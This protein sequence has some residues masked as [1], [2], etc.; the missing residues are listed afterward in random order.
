MNCNNCKLALESDANYCGNCGKPV[1]S[2]TSL[3]SVVNSPITIETIL[4]LYALPKHINNN[5]LRYTLAICAGIM[6]II[7][8]LFIPIVGLAFSVTGFIVIS[9]TPHGVHRKLKWSAFIL[10]IIGLL[11]SLGSIAYLA[12]HATS[13]ISNGKQSSQSAISNL[14]TPCYSA[15]FSPPVNLTKDLSSCSF[16]ARTVNSGLSATNYFKVISASQPKLTSINLLT[17]V[18]P[19]LEADARINLPGFEIINE[20]S[21]LF[22]GSPAYDIEL[23]NQNQKVSAIELAVLHPT[24]KGDN[25]FVLVNINSKTTA[26]LNELKSSW[27]WH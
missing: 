16:I 8:A 7:G 13:N 25:L 18:K 6:G 19:A 21:L 2:L 14:N 4:P 11:I 1:Q 27:Q 9:L 22:V 15:Y 12:S 3:S 10:S 24:T 26:N 23:Y 17:I 5:Y 20:R